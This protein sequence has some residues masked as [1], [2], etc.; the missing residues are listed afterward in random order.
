MKRYLYP[1]LLLCAGLIMCR[2]AATLALGNPSE[3]AFRP[4][5]QQQHLLQASAADLSR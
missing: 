4:A 2:D 1:A 3:R 5:G